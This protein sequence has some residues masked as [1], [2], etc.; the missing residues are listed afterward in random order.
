[1]PLNNQQV[2]TARDSLKTV[3]SSVAESGSNFDLAIGKYNTLL[4]AFAVNNNVP[5]ESMRSEVNRM[6][7]LSGYTESVNIQVNSIYNGILDD[8]FEL[9]KTL[10]GTEEGYSADSLAALNAKKQIDIDEFAKVSNNINS[11]ITRLLIANSIDPIP[12]DV[13]LGQI[14]ALMSQFKARTN[15]WVDTSITSFYNESNTRLATD[16]GINLF[17]YV[18]PNDS[19]EREFCDIHNGQ[20][21]TKEEWNKLNNGQLNP[22]FTFNGGFRCRHQMIGI[23]DE[24]LGEQIA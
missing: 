4:Q 3:D 20:V 2:A 22:V 15:S 14:S 6:F 7:V 11:D 5:F 8:S 1:M 17:Q 16:V 18:G 23:P 9:S 12:E 24:A 21:K 10:Y 19:R 13:L